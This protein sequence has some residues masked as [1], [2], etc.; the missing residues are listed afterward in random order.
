MSDNED[1]EEE[2]EPDCGGEGEEVEADGGQRGDEEDG[3]GSDNIDEAGA[4]T[5]DIEGEE[6]VQYAESAGDDEIPAFGRSMGGKQP[7]REAAAEHE[8]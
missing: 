6:A 5:E 4:L 3:E 2:E 1:D 8:P 7:G